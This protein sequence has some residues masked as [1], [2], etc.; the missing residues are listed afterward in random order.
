MISPRCGPVPAEIQLTRGVDAFHCRSHGNAMTARHALAT[1]LLAALGLL[2]GRG[3]AAHDWYT[4][5]RQ[6][7]TGRS[8]CG[9]YDCAPLRSEQIRYIDGGRMQFFL[10]GAWRDVD[11]AVILERASP[12][13]R[14]H[15][16]WNSPAQQ[17]LCVILPGT[18]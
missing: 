1:I 9:G 6:P 10:D 5:L 11:P 12:D 16:C 15:A 7:G 13:G 17:L 14:V 18:L 8:C 3:A 2:P 4:G